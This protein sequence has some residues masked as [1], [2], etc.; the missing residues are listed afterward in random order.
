M[1]VPNKYTQILSILNLRC[2]AYQ[3][4]ELIDYHQIHLNINTLIKYLTY[5]SSQIIIIFESWVGR[6]GSLGPYR[7]S[8]IEHF[9]LI[10]LIEGL[11]RKFQI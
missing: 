1:T 11:K 5:I 10:W 2:W 9:A 6:L 7:T 8:G 4:K 3:R